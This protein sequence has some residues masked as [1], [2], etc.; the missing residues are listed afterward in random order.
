VQALRNHEI[1]Q[2]R[3]RIRDFYSNTVLRKSKLDELLLR[4]TAKLISIH[5]QITFINHIISTPYRNH[6]GTKLC[7]TLSL[8]HDVMAHMT[9]EINIVVVTKHLGIGP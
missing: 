6:V 8:Q 9:L 3:Q 4:H 2:S 1:S 5:E 7:N